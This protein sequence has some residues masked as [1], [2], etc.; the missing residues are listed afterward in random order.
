MQTSSS[1][2]Q[3]EHQAAV[4]AQM[5]ALLAA[6]RQGS[7]SRG[8]DRKRFT[9][10]T[11]LSTTLASLKPRDDSADPALPRQANMRDAQPRRAPK[12]EAAYDMADPAPP[13]EGGKRDAQT[14]RAPKPEAAYDMADPA[15]PR[16]ASERA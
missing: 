10:L 8:L 14:R 12:P 3:A 11:Q 5:S 6:N 16:Q 13:R 9:H 2:Q 4:A 15:P 1:P 7:K